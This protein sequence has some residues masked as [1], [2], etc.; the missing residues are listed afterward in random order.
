MAKTEVININGKTQFG[1]NVT[2]I[3]GMTGANRREDLMLIQALFNYIAKGL[4]P[5][6]LGLGGDYNIPEINGDWDADTSLAIC[7]FQI[8]NAGRLLRNKFDG[9]IH[10]ASY[11][12]RIIR[13]VNGRLMSIT[14]LHQ[15]ATDAAV[16]QGHFE[17]REGLIKLKPELAKYLDRFIADL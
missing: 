14:L 9:H 7:E 12:N 3:V 5:Q 2:D 4:G 10:P 16:M 8:R 6:L 13:G 11:K 1:V 17:Y 15:M